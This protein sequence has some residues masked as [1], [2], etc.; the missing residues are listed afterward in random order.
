VTQRI[1][2]GERGLISFYQAWPNA[3][4][5]VGADPS[6]PGTLSHRAFKHCEP[7]TAATSLGWLIYPPIDFDLRWD[8]QVCLW[9]R[10]DNKE[11]NVLRIVVAEEVTAAFLQESESSGIKFN[12]TYPFLSA[13]PEPGV[14]Q[15]WSGLVVKTAPGWSTL[16]RS[17][18]NRPSDGIIET[19]DGLIETDWWTGPLLSVFRLVKTDISVEFRTKRPFAQVQLVSRDAR[20]AATIGQV[21]ACTSLEAWPTTL[22]T[23]F[24]HQI[25]EGETKEHRPGSY[26]RAVRS[27]LR[28]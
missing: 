22:R 1:S 27:R 13:A 10:A 2:N 24:D 5:P 25:I 12:G 19:F 21:A 8:G 16:V 23:E 18:V 4:S 6:N 17:V 15:M 28:S 11:W 14:I 9:K 20:T 7:L 26:K 3:P